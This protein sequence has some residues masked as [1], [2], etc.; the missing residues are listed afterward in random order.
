[1]F[2]NKKSKENNKDSN[3]NFDL[4]LNVQRQ[5]TVN[6]I[7]LNCPHYKTDGQVLQTALCLGLNMMEDLATY[8]AEY[9]KIEDGKQSTLVLPS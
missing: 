1:M 3:K 2:W 5:A 4:K 6:I 8:Q 9:I 7:K